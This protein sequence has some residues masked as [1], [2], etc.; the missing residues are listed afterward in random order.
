MIQPGVSCEPDHCIGDLPGVAAIDDEAFHA[1]V[2]NGCRPAL[3]RS[4][5]R[6]TSGQG[7]NLGA[8]DAFLLRWKNKRRAGLEQSGNFEV[9]QTFAMGEKAPP[10]GQLFAKIRFDIS[11]TNQLGVR[12]LPLH[13]LKGA[14]QILVPL[15]QADGADA[16]E[17][18]LCRHTLA[19]FENRSVHAHGVDEDLFGRNAIGDH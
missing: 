18:R 4:D 19:L 16:D 13:Q 12:Q 15:T 8:R 11:D 7:F 10:L 5:E 3:M 2:N 9:A 6:Q 17:T 14:K 1:V